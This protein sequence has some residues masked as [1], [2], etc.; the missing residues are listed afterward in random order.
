MFA[1]I[2]CATLQQASAQ[3]RYIGWQGTG[4]NWSDPANWNN[5]FEYGQLNWTGGGNPTSWNDRG[6]LSQWRFYLTNAT[7]YTLGGDAV[8]FYDNSGQRGGVLSDSSVLQ[9]INM[10]VSFADFDAT[11][12]MFVL[13][14]QAGGVTFGGTVTLSN[15]GGAFGIGGSN[16]SSTISFNNT[17][18]GTKP[19]VVGTNAFD[20]NTAGMGATRAVFSGNNTYTGA[21]TV[22][23]GSLTISHANA[24]GATNSGTTVSWGATLNL[25]NNITVA[26][27]ALTLAGN[28][29]NNEGALR[30]V[31]GSNTYLGLITASTALTRVGAAS[32]AT[33]VLN[34]VNSGSQE[35]WVVGDGTTIVA[36]GATN[37]GSGTAFVKFGT[38]TAVL[39]SSNAWSGNEFLREGT[40]ILSNNNALGAGGVATI[41]NVGGSSATATLTLGESII[42]SNAIIVQ[43]G[44]TGV[45]TLG[46]QSA[47][48]G[49]QLGS[50]TLNTN[51]L[52][53]NIASGGTL[54]FGGGV[55][56]NTDGTGNNRF[57]VDGG[58]T[59]LVTNNGTGLASSDRYQV[60]VGNG[61]LLIGGGTISARTNVAGLG[62]AIDLGVSLSGVL[63]NATSALRASNGVTIS[64]SIY[65]GTTN[66]QAR[67]LGASGA[68][69]SVTYS[70]EIGLGGSPVTID[71]TNGQTV[72][73]SGPITNVFGAGAVVKTNDGLAILSGDNS[74]SGTT[75]VTNGTLRIA[76]STALGSAAGGTIVGSGATLELSNNVN[77]VGE[78]ITL[79][80][81]GMGGNGALRNL[82]G[83]NTNTGTLTL[84]SDGRIQ[85]EEGTS[86]T[87]SGTVNNGGHNLTVHSLGTTVISGAITNTGGLTQS[88]GGTL[89]LSGN[90]TFSGAT[91]IAGGTLQI[92]GN[93]RL[94]N[95]N[96][97][98]TISNAG[99]LRVTSAADITNAITIGA[100]HGVLSNASS[101]EVVYSGAV[102]KDGTTL[103]S[104]AGEGT[105]VFTGVISGDS[106]NSDFVVDGGTTVFSN[107]MTYN[108][109]TIITNGGTLVLGADNAMPSGSDLILG[110]GTF[111]VGVWD[112]N[113][114]GTLAM[115]SLTLSASSTIDLGD[116]GTSG[117]R[118][119]V[120][121]SSVG[122]TW[123]GTLTI[124]N[125]QGVA[126]TQSDVTRL[127]FGTG[128]LDSLQLAQIQFAGYEQGAVLVDGEL[129][130]IPEAPVVWGA[131]AVVGFILLRERQRLRRLLGVFI[132]IRR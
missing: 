109:P 32:G 130:P 60:R 114:A 18:A 124:T 42:N 5:T 101:G 119:L 93:S 81:T 120:F 33:L 41:G 94:G 64:N 106:A 115:G 68:S 8:E 45:R 67:I 86:L 30:S 9:T 63:V 71:A 129:A 123:S 35:F 74:Y 128:G 39:M 20:G 78:F 132:S 76:G 53:F 55:T 24:L 77:V 26:G 108:G 13:T 47:G 88:G 28:G 2:F 121:A 16:A 51:S 48:T 131:L 80:G 62:H 61:T 46:Y 7:A 113:A 102:S 75:T 4:T 70:G 54:L 112:Y 104:A 91:T 36:G 56:V 19:V 111:R 29:L 58:G 117:D 105:N 3:F 1:L 125:W 99:T 21:T 100:G 118:N 15:G 59:L 17:I 127:L 107:Q 83:D 79:N 90:N 103:T 57:A 122:I 89:T 98:L 37:S 25:S 92:D 126:R 95:T 52:A 14:R 96:T 22:A 97:T 12:S 65:V 40:V 84:A 50:I 6:S 110:G 49:M 43:G 31:S 72:T 23:G 82:S 116:F 38:G 87:Q 11:R 69:S 44:G 27:E 34:N 10:N 85:T 66:N 73:I